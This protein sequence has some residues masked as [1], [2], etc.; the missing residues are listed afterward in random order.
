MIYYIIRPSSWKPSWI[1][2]PR[3]LAMSRS[4]S[5]IIVCFA[6]NKFWPKFDPLKDLLQTSSLQAHII[7]LLTTNSIFQSS[8]GGE[9][10]GLECC[11]TR[12]ERSNKVVE[13]QNFVDNKFWYDCSG[14]CLVLRK[15]WRKQRRS[16]WWRTR[17]LTR[18]PPLPMTLRGWRRWETNKFPLFKILGPMPPSGRQT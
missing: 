10:K 7:H 3:S 18:Q 2:L 13:K 12:D 11:W 15:T 5:C 16:F 8:A 6:T 4:R 14:G 1:S 17:S 9:R